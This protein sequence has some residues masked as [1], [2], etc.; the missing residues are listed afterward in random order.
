MKDGYVDWKLILFS[1]PRDR[2]KQRTR[3]STHF[4]YCN[5]VKKICRL[6]SVLTRAARL[7]TIPT[8]SA[9]LKSAFNCRTASI[10]RL[11]ARLA[12]S[13]SSQTTCRR[14]VT[15]PAKILTYM[16]E[17]QPALHTSCRPAT[18]LRHHDYSRSPVRPY[19]TIGVL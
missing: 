16:T 13:S 18:A 4:D 11:S 8:N 2:R 12:Q 19:V 9:R 7:S 17:Q 14:F 6:V 15:A 10:C 3:R 5:I 1:S